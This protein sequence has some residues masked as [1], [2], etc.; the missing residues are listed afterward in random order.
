VTNTLV[1]SGTLENYSRKKAYGTGFTTLNLLYLHVI[2]QD[3][4]FFLLKS[5]KKILPELLQFSRKK[6]EGSEALNWETFF[7]EK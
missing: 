5:K 4:S 6:L 2:S 1:Y 3:F 7:A